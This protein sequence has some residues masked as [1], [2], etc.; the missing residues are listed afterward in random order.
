[1]IQLTGTVGPV[2]IFS[3]VQSSWDSDCG[4]DRTRL[5]DVLLLFGVIVVAAVAVVNVLRQRTT[6]R[7]ANKPTSP[8]AIIATL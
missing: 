4:Y 8:T 5:L 2:P 6:P 1:M 7:T 3:G